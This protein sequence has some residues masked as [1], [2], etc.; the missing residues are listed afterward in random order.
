MTGFGNSGNLTAT[1]PHA[2]AGVLEALHQQG[3]P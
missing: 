3:M 1:R 2:A